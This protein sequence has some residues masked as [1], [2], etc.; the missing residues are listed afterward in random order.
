MSADGLRAYIRTLR[1]GRKVSQP[2]LAAAIDMPLRT[3]K[4][5][6]AGKT[7]TIKTS[8][9]LRAIRYLRGSLDQLADM[10]VD[11]TADDGVQLA[12]AWL[13]RRDVAPLVGASDDTPE[14]DARLSQLI[15]LLARGVDPATAARRVQDELRG[16]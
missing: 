16:Q 13:E 15:E 5:W 11:A 12:R 7:V 14:Q 9:L 3:Y 1:Q 8:F 10:P 2:K 4:S 6:E